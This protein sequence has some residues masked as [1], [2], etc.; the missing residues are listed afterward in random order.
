MTTSKNSSQND[1]SHE[2]P[3]GGNS[4]FRLFR[5]IE[6]TIAG[7][8]DFGARF[9]RTCWLILAHPRAFISLLPGQAVGKKI[10]RPYT[11]LFVSICLLDLILGRLSLVEAKFWQGTRELLGATGPRALTLESFIRSTA[12]TVAVV[13]IVAFIIERTLI[14][15]NGA[16][17]GK[18]RELVCYAIGYAFAVTS[19]L[20][21]PLISLVGKIEKS[22]SHDI[23][24]YI[25]HLPIPLL[26]VYLCIY[27][28]WL[29]LSGIE[30][31]NLSIRKSLRLIAKPSIAIAIWFS[32]GLGL[33][34]A[35]TSGRDDVKS[36]SAPEPVLAS[37]IGYKSGE[38]CKGKPKVCRLEVTLLLVN[39]NKAPLVISQH[40][41]HA[42]VGWWEASGSILLAETEHSSHPLELF[43]TGSQSTELIVLKPREPV[44]LTA[45]ISGVSPPT[46]TQSNGEKSGIFGS[47]QLSIR[48]LRPGGN[49]E[50]LTIGNVGF[51]LEMTR[52]NSFVQEESKGPTKALPR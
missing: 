27:P 9:L 23:V 1:K 24:Q 40:G 26:M 4:E 13:I 29:F 34:N 45:R 15:N 30:D 10:A 47:L 12:P 8:I 38:I 39:N 17:R 41:H 37:L 44:F 51:A 28:L 49:P 48:A 33:Q 32:V 22:I 21:I 42:F 11:Y 35:A 52:S 14:A 25:V 16:A 31:F 7:V 6:D 20:A 50:M 3:Q 19:I 46:R 2:P 18:A 36:E 5:L 43:S